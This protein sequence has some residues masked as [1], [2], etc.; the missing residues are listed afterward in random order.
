MTDV[1]VE[2][3]VVD[4]AVVVVAAPVPPLDVDPLDP[5]ELDEPVA[6]VEEVPV[7]EP[8]VPELA[9]T[10]WLKGSRSGPVSRA[11]L[12]V[13]VT[14]TAGSAG[15]GVLADPVTGVG[16]TATVLPELERSTG[17]ATSAMISAAAT[18]HSRFSRSSEIRFRTV[19]MGWEA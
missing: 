7:L 1:V 16:E 8:V 15:V 18:G 2:V 14:L 19:F 17:T 3:V 9:F 10:C 6:A 4:V 11:S 13:V 12:G 5:V